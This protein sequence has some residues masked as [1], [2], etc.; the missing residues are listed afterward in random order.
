M[1]H[2]DLVIMQ[3]RV[4]TNWRG[5]KHMRKN[6]SWNEL[7]ILGGFLPKGT[8]QDEFVF[9]DES[10]ENVEFLRDILNKLAAKYELRFE[11]LRI[12]SQPVLLDEWV[13]ALMSVGGKCCEFSSNPDDLDLRILDV[14]MLGIVRQLNR[15]GLLTRFSCEGHGKKNPCVQLI[16]HNIATKAYILLRELG[17]AVKRKGIN[18]V[19]IKEDV[20][21]LY[22]ISLELSQLESVYDSNVKEYI[23]EKHR[24]VLEELLMVPGKSLE[25][26]KVRIHLMKFLPKLL[27]KVEVDSYGNILGQKRFGSGP[28]VLLSAHMDVVDSIKENSK[29]IKHNNIWKRDQGILGADDRAGVAMIINIL[30]HLNATNF[31]GKIKIALTVEEEIGQYGASNINKDFFEGIDKAISLDR[32]NG[33]DIVIKSHFQDYGSAEYGKIFEKA[34]HLLGYV[35]GTYK[36]VHGGVSDLRVWSK[37]GIESVNL[38]IGYYNEHTYDEYLNVD[39]WH[40]TYELVIKSLNMMSNQLKRGSCSTSSILD[41]S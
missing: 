38:S 7:L 18:V 28:T 5:E 22:E 31:R 21:K 6:L 8:E 32:R 16:D 3:L 12:F 11:S 37:L 20:S 27:D 36:I 13:T 17:V 2:S 30:S 33:S 4:I 15:L 1:C 41:R 25:E 26:D 29:I 35:K 39:E 19:E 23:Y 40:Q 24:K 14:S 9:Y 34:A 10:I